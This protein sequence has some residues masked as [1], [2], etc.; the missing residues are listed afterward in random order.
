MSGPRENIQFMTLHIEFEKVNLF[1][2]IVPAVRI[3][4]IYLYTCYQVHLKSSVAELP[5]G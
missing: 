2:A 5:L 4:C 3:D 1:Y